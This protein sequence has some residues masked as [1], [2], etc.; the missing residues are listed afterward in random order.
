MEWLEENKIP[1]GK[2]SKAVVDWLTD[3]AAFVFSAIEA[4]LEVIIKLILAVLQF[5]PALLMVRLLPDLLFGLNA[6][7]HSRSPLH[8][9][10][11]SS[12]IKVIGKKLLKR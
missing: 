8:W 9:A 12:S 2:W 4:V 1:V 7:C 6:R 11:C 10:C 3:N 5:P